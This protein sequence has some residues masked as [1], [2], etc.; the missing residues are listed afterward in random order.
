MPSLLPS[1][2]HMAQLRAED[3]DPRCPFDGHREG[4]FSGDNRGH[5]F[6]LP[7]QNQLRGRYRSQKDGEKSLCSVT[8]RAGLENAPNLRPQGRL[9]SSPFLL[10]ELRHPECR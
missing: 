9:R 7:V 1:L 4:R 6:T 3:R 5:Q 10:W 2:I 8:G